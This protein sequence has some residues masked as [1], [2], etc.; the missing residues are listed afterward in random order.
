MSAEASTEPSYL[1]AV[2]AI[3]G[4]PALVGVVGV[5]D[6][7]PLPERPASIAGV[8]VGGVLLGLIGA[9]VGYLR[10]HRLIVAPAV[11]VLGVIGGAG[12]ALVA[13][14]VTS[15]Q[16]ASTVIIE[17]DPVLSRFVG[18]S[19]LLLLSVAS[20]AVLEA[21]TGGQS[22]GYTPPTATTQVGHLAALAYGFFAGLL[23]AVLSLVPGV[24]LGDPVSEPSQLLYAAFG[25]ILGG[26]LIGYFRLKYRILSPL[27]VLFIV[28]GAAVVGVT[29][30]GS[31]RGFP[32]AWPVWIGIVVILAVI[33][34]LA[35]GIQARIVGR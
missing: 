9:L 10:T 24:L 17:G 32:M 1:P 18:V 4:I 5:L 27:L 19:P 29:A 11:A 23:L 7:Y 35:R 2:A 8:V 14:G 22:S 20:L 31:P 15:V 33:E 13:P 34:G 6:G 3:I 21:A 12:W 26:M 30:G 25:G 28:A 16:V